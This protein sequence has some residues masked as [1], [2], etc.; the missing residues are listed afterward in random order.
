MY[1][2]LPLGPDGAPAILMLDTKLRQLQGKI[3]Q[4]DRQAIPRPEPSQYG[5]IEAELGRFA[6]SLGAVLRISTL[7]DRLEHMK[8]Q[9]GTDAGRSIITLLSML[10]HRIS[11]AFWNHY[12]CRLFR[13][14]QTAWLFC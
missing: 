9:V 12:G 1:Q 14:M 4:L 7:L 3:S 8:S 5:A 10:R 2:K 11:T 6:G 13:Y